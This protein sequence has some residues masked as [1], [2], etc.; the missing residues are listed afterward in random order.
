VKDE[1]KDEMKRVAEREKVEER[2]RGD[3]VRLPQ[4]V[5][6]PSHSTTSLSALALY[7]LPFG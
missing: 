6:G 1:R 5:L 7:L 3:G 4:L 2:E